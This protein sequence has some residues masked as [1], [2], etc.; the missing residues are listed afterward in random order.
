MTRFRFAILMTGFLGTAVFGLAL[1]GT[2]F[3]GDSAKCTIATSG[4]SAPAKACA[5]G[6]RAEAKKT[7]KAMVADA[8]AHG[9]KFTCD[10]CHKDLESY[11]L[12]NTAKDDLKQ[13]EALLAK[14]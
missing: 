13:L 1:S 10:G 7:M 8:K 5:K 6:G 2:A 3:A 12:T 4:N 14:K 9:H 11:E